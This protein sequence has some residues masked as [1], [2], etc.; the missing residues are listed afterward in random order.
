MNIQIAKP[1]V[2]VAVASFSLYSISMINT[3]NIT[4]ENS[5][6]SYIGEPE[7]HFRDDAL[8][9]L[10]EGDFQ[11][12]FKSPVIQKNKNEIY[13]IKANIEQILGRE[14]KYSLRFNAELDTYFFAIITNDEN[15]DNDYAKLDQMDEQLKDSSYKGKKIVVTL[16]EEDV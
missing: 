10:D 4:I 16:E 15:F 3:D 2:N 14:I 1:I 12:I 8:R 13:L 5:S 7:F 11:I 6:N 9:K